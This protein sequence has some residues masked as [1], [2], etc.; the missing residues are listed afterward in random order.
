MSEF[1]FSLAMTV[2]SF[3]LPLA[4]LALAVCV[5]VL[6]PMALFRVTRPY[7]GVG[8]FLASWIFGLTTWTLGAAV[9]FA[10]YGWVGLIIGLFLF[11]VGVVP[12][13]I[14][15]AFVTLKSA[16]LGFSLIAMLV[17]VIAARIG[18]MAL[19]EAGGR[20]QGG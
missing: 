4:W 9:T 15:A 2:Y 17:V 13:G 18:G 8:L 3:A 12:I 11:G 19:A 14:F 7:A 5:V 6:L 20:P 1:L 16:S 10:T